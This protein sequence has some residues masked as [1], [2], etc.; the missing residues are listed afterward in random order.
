[1]KVRESNIILYAKC[2]LL[3]HR[4]KSPVEQC[5]LLELENSISTKKGKPIRLRLVYFHLNHHKLA[6]TTK[7]YLFLLHNL[8]Q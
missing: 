2:L 4:K 1:M 7:F 6:P 3:N 5:Y 8:F